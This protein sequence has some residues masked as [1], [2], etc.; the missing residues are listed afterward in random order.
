MQQ[1]F[2][3]R[4]PLTSMQMRAHSRCKA[5]QIQDRWQVQHLSSLSAG[6]LWCR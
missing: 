4:L 3:S 1:S 2:F 5:R 6:T